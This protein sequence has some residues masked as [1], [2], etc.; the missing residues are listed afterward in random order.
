M[1][2]FHYQLHLHQ[3]MH[4]YRQFNQLPSLQNPVLTIGVFDGVHLG[5][6]QILRQVCLE[7]EKVHGTPVVIT[8]D[9]HPRKVLEPNKKNTLFILTTLEERLS[10]F[11]KNGIEHVVVVHF[12]EAFAHQ[13]AES[14]IS[15]FLVGNFHPHTI[16]LGYDHHFGKDRKGDYHLLELAGEKYHFLVKE[17]PEQVINHIAISSTRIREALQVGDISSANELLGYPYHFSG[18]VIHGNKRGRT[19]GFPTANILIKEDEKLIP[20]VGVYGVRVHLDDDEFKGMMNIGYRPT[21]DGT[22]LT[23]EVHILDFDRDIYHSTLH[24]SILKRIRDEKKFSGLEELKKQLEK[25]REE[26][27]L[28]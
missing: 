12:D 21:V 5:H 15:D 11:E 7:S 23:I 25:D 6:V 27:Y 18:E 14:Y 16:I 17:I 1:A 24:I 20:A 10:L 22:S 3:F 8:F 26:A 9:P 28:D 13:T 4:V 2:I 19:I